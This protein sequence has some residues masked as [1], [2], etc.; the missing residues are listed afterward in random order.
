MNQK[1]SRELAEEIAAEMKRSAVTEGLDHTIP[2][3]LADILFRLGSNPAPGGQL[4][5][6]LDD[7]SR[8]VE[9]GM[10]QAGV[11]LEFDV[12]VGQFPT[13]SFNAQAKRTSAGVL[14]LIN[15]GLMMLIHQSV[16]ILSYAIRFTEYGE[17][18]NVVFADDPDHP[19]GHSQKE[20]IDA[21]TEVVVAYLRFEGEEGSRRAMRFPAQADR[22]GYIAQRL[23]E[24]CELFAVA[25]EYGHAIDG[26]LSKPRSVLKSTSVGEME[27]VEKEWNQEFVA[28]ALGANLMLRQFEVIADD[29]GDDFSRQWELL[30]IVAAPLFFFA[31]D[32]L[33]TEARGLPGDTP[34]A[35]VLDHPPSVERAASIRQYVHDYMIKSTGLP[36]G[37]K[38]FWWADQILDL[39]AFMT[40]AVLARLGERR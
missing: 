8:R 12:F 24:N 34:G 1:L 6:I 26:H 40:D 20:I 19:A 23:T 33:V 31:L 4:Q 2:D 35:A 16:K 14:I 17:G 9:A 13:G 5:G 27:L 25:H 7:L 22:R 32:N 11:S 38:I 29:L 37:G 36:D 39:M 15:T 10:A 3:D 28:D 21:L 30:N 18:G